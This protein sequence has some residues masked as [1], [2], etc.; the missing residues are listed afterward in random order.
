MNHETYRELVALELYGELDAAETS[1]LQDHLRDCASCRDLRSELAGSLGVLRDRADHDRYGDSADTLPADWLERMRATSAARPRRAG[2]PL[3]LTS[4]VSGLAAGLLVMAT[5]GDGRE[6]ERAV[7]ALVPSNGSA[8]VS[9][10]V[11]EPARPRS[12]RTAPFVPGTEPPPRATSRGLLAHASKA[13]VADLR[14][15]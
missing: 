10:F 5:W 6:T 12:P 3:A 14:D 4:F 1:R 15:R 8:A 2:V 9:P 11:A 13:R 7:T